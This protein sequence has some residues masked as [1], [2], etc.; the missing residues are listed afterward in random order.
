MKAL[1][2]I[3]C[4]IF[5]SLQ[6]TT[7]AVQASGLRISADMI[8]DALKA[9]GYEVHSVTT[10][11]LRRARIVASSGGIWREVVLDLSTGQILRDYAVEFAP[12]DLPPPGTNTMP[13]GGTVLTDNAIPELRN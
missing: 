7:S 4:A 9:Q 1:I 11:L 8:T 5:L 6:I 12:T 3:I 2:K 10:T 13:R